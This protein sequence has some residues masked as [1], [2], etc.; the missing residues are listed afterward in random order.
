MQE[1]VAEI[2]RQAGNRQLE[3]V[4]LLAL[5]STLADRGARARVRPL[6]SRLDRLVPQD[7]WMRFLLDDAKALVAAFDGDFVPA[8][9]LV[10]P[11]LSEGASEKVPCFLAGMIA[12]W[13]GD[14]VLARRALAVAERTVYAKGAFATALQWLRAVE[15]LID[16]DLDAARRLLHD[17]APWVM[18]SSS[19]RLRFWRAEV[20]ARGG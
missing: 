1:R 19:A 18:A 2:G 15:P 9:Q 5:A 7:A 4:P 16:D 12:L 20:G 3:L 13:T 14:R 10:E 6:I 8:R 11:Y 17:P